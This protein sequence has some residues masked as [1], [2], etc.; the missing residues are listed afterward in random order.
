MPC[1]K[2]GIAYENIAEVIIQ[3]PE[4]QLKQL[5]FLIRINSIKLMSGGFK[6]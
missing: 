2:Q 5:Y 1:D 6:V 4:K 3:N